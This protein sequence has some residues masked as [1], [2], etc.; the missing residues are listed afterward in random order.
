MPS[1]MNYAQ[2]IAELTPEQRKLLQLRLRVQGLHL[3]SVSVV[4]RPETGA[5]SPLSFQQRRLWFLQELSPASTAYNIVS[6]VLLTGD[7]NVAAMVRSFSMMIDRHEI[8]RTAFINIRGTPAQEPRAMTKLPITCMNWMGRNEDPEDIIRSVLIRESSTP[9]DLSQLPLFRIAIAKIAEGK[10]FVVVTAHHILID[11]WSVAIFRQEQA[12]AYNAIVKGTSAALPELPFQYADYATSQREQLTPAYLEHEVE[13][14]A[15]KLNGA[16]HNIVLPSH[17]EAGST[18]TPARG[19]ELFSIDATIS[20]GI[21]TLSCELGLTPF[22]FL[23]GVLQVLL[24][25]VSHQDD[26]VVGTTLANRDSRELELLVGLFANTLPIRTRFTPSLTVRDLL[27]QIRESTLD[28]LAHEHVPFELIVEKLCPPRTLNHHPLFQVLFSFHNNPASGIGL[29]GLDA[30]PY[31]EAGGMARY[32]LALEMSEAG[33]SFRGTL[34]YNCDAFTVDSILMLI[35]YF[36]KL[37]AWMLVNRDLKISDFPDNAFHRAIGY[38]AVSAQPVITLNDNR[39]PDVFLASQSA[40]EKRVAGVVVKL[41]DLP[42]VS[43]NASFF[44]IG[45]NSFLAAQLVWLLE[46]EFKAK[47]SLATIFACST[48]SDIAWHIE[49]AIASRSLHRPAVGGCVQ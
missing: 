16:P 15:H 36:H 47:I 7:L 37:A 42:A 9:F 22:M 25:L 45:G 6:A 35:D 14:L 13:Y 32:E 20:A 28:L 30:Q 31:K 2:R 46:E 24:H 27:A 33:D 12:F 38:G 11:A 8:L 49:K 41:L 5:T 23:L 3:P 19:I 26:V 44:S 40:L 43:M 17:R 34:E 1:K 18:L 21:K 48:L 4:K 29:E 39:N 10:H